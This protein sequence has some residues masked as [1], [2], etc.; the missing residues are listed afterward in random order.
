MA[1][2][3]EDTFIVLFL[4]WRA[5]QAAAAEAA[6]RHFTQDADDPVHRQVQRFILRQ[7]QAVEK[8]RHADILRF[9]RRQRSALR[10]L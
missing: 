5:A 2:D 10:V 6:A 9:E 1:V 8:R 3:K 4:R 7:F